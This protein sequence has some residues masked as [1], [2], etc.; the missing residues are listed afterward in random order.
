MRTL[1]RPAPHGAR[2]VEPAFGVGAPCLV[3][4]FVGRPFR[5][6]RQR[7]VCRHDQSAE[8]GVAPVEIAIEGGRCELE[9]AGHR[10]QGEGGGALFG[11]VLTGHGQDL[12]GHLLPH[13]LS[14]RPGCS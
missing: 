11:Q 7:L 12:G 13:P 9:V 3:R 4:R 1:E 2:H 10:A 8:K 6:G 14:G 5:L